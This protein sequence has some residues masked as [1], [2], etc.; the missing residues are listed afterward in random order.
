MRFDQTFLHFW[1]PI[2]Q[3]HICV[4]IWRYWWSD[5][6]YIIS[7]FIWIFICHNVTSLVFNLIFRWY[8]IRVCWQVFYSPTFFSWYA[9]VYQIYFRQICWIILRTYCKRPIWF[10]WVG[11]VLCF[12]NDV[13]MIDLA[14]LVGQ[15]TAVGGGDV[16][17]VEDV[18]VAGEVVVAVED[19]VVAGDVAVVVDVVCWLLFLGCA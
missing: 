12:V 15:I 2:I 10:V 11:V 19:V 16:V 14:V 5:E 9:A 8:W 6:L 4:T 18:I 13:D 7:F 3:F 1:Y 17:I